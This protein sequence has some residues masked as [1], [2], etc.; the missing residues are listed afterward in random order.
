MRVGVPAPSALAGFYGELGL[1]SGDGSTFAGTEGGTQVAV[2]EYPFR[3]L[4]EVEIGASDERDLFLVAGRLTGLGLEANLDD[5]SVSVIDPTTQITFRVRVVAPLVQQPPPDRVPD[6]R[7]AVSLRRNARADG[8]FQGSRPP[9]RLGH[10][11]IGC[12][13]LASTQRLLVDGIGCKV[14]D[15]FPGI[16]SFLRCSTDHHNIGLVGS[17]V[18]TLQHY[19]W[20]CDDLDHVGHSATALL[21]A[22]PERQAWGFGRHF[23]G[24]NY[25]WYLHDSAGAFLELYSDMDVIDDDD[26]WEASGRTPVEFEHIAN[27]WGPAIPTEFI[28][29]SD[30]EHLQAAWAARD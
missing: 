7:P 17:P 16:I 21:R 30:L 11:V 5:G 6:N 9:R 3:R 22:D 23:I 1:V 27:S 25:Y 20:E 4:L 2:D 18:P 13:D 28:V 29:P 12:P 8:V 14:S 19:S 24:S 26:A 10:L 15:E